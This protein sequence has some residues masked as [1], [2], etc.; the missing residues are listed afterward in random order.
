MHHVHRLAGIAAIALTAAAL[1]A[2][3]PPPQPNV[4]AAPSTLPP[5][6]LPPTA[7]TPG[8]PQ[9]VAVT[10][11]PQYGPLRSHRRRNMGRRRRQ[12]P[13]RAAPARFRGSS[14]PSRHRRRRSRLRRPRRPRVWPGSRDIGAGAGSKAGMRGRPATMCRVLPQPPTGSLAIGS[15]APPVG[16]GSKA[17]GLSELG[18]VGAVGCRGQWQFYKE[19]RV[20]LLNAQYMV[21]GE[22]RM[23]LG[24]QRLATRR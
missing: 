17:A 11:P 21:P 13:P 22:Q 2:C 15:K 16:F 1:S 3:Y 18:L 5:V 9:A 4:A 10:P 8:Y 7:T 14:H 24:P 12:P 23:V 6:Y 19:H 20:S